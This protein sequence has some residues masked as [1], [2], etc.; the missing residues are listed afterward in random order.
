MGR[1]MANNSLFLNIATVLWAVNIS[2]RKDEGGNP[3]LP[4]I[5]DSI[6]GL[7]TL[8]SSIIRS[9]Q[10]ITTSS[11]PSRYPLP[12]D[13]LITPRFPEVKTVI[14]QTRELLE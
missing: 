11:L 12:F 8:V 4:D 6:P 1:F 7:G 13:C 2:A 10:P 5:L 14:A 9:F 3:I